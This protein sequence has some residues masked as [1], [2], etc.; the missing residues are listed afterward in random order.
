[1]VGKAFI[2]VVAV[3][4]W[5]IYYRTG[6]DVYSI[7]SFVAL[8]LRSV[9]SRSVE[10]YSIVAFISVNS[11]AVLK[12]SGRTYV[13]RIIAVVAVNKSALDLSVH[14]KGIV[15][16]SAV[17]SSAGATANPYE[18]ALIKIDRVVTVAGIYLSVSVIQHGARFYIYYIV[19]VAS[20]YIRVYVAKISTHIYRIV[21]VTS[22]YRLTKALG[23]VYVV[24]VVYY[25]TVC[26]TWGYL[27]IVSSD[28]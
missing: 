7:V 22:K 20:S 17:Y 6:F 5:I 28:V 15:A 10:I 8:D 14:V 19:S 27:R 24:I 2:Y 16:V 13:K 1:M 3:Y 12:N 26:T 23:Y 11:R 18:W 25:S 21:A 4:R 9:F